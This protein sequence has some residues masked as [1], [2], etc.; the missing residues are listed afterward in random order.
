MLTLIDFEWI[1]PVK[2]INVLGRNILYKRVRI[3]CCFIETILDN[4]EK[5]A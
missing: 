4:R 5:S 2:L 3:T 1:G